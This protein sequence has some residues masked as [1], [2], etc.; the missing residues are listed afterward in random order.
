[1]NLSPA[2]AAI[3]LITLAGCAPGKSSRSAAPLWQ[4]DSEFDGATKVCQLAR[5]DMSRSLVIIHT[6]IPKVPKLG[7]VFFLFHAPE[8]IT[9]ANMR[10][11]VTLQYD[12]EWRTGFLS[13][14]DET[15]V[16]IDP[17]TMMLKDIFDP[18]ETA[19]MLDVKVLASGAVVHFDLSG[20]PEALPALRA[21]AAEGLAL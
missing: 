2:I 19:T 3:L 14:V 5:K 8:L 13:A 16:R 4:L 12:T 11:A 1:M 15:V 20:L 18:M 7:T 9:A 10:W 21:C 6:R 17:N